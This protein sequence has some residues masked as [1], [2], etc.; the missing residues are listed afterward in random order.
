MRRVLTT[1]HRVAAQALRAGRD[2]LRGFT[3]L[4]GVAS[5]GPG[6]PPRATESPAAAREAL[7]DHAARRRSCC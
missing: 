2:F 6:T 1:L 7:C 5:G 4:A 3:G